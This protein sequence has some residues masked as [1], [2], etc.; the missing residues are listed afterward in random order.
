MGRESIAEYLEAIHSD[1]DC[2]QSDE[3]DE[4]STWC[5]LEQISEEEYCCP[6]SSSDTIVRYVSNEISTPS[7]LNSS[8]ASDSDEL[9]KAVSCFDLPGPAHS[10]DTTYYPSTREHLPSAMQG[11]SS[12]PGHILKDSDRL[13]P[14]QFSFVR[15]ALLQNCQ[16]KGSK[17]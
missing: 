11:L 13:T 17:T 4:D 5:P 12:T 6:I 2:D 8:V 15:T 9:Q 7:G 16:E 3:R 14:S 10:L 1:S